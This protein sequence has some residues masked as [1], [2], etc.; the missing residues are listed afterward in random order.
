MSPDLLKDSVLIFYIIENGTSMPP[1][2]IA[3]SVL[4]SKFKYPLHATGYQTVTFHTWNY[5]KCDVA[6]VSVLYLRRYLEKIVS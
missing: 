2:T 3:Y 4:Q 6:P 5:R 1:L